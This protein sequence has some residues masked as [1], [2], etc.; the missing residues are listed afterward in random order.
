M[1]I[2]PKMRHTYVGI[3]SHRDTHTAVFIDCFFEKLGEITFKNRPSEFPAFL[4]DALKLRQDDTDL[5]FGLEDVSMYGRTLSVFFQKNNLRIKHVNSLLVSRERKNQNVTEKTDSV[6]AECA[7]RVLLSKLSELPD[8]QLDDKYWILRT[9]VTHRDFI[10]KQNASSKNHLHNLVVQH[11]PNYCELFPNIDAKSALAF[12]KRYPSP[13]TLDGTTHEEL[14]KFLS[15]ASDYRVGAGKPGEVK[16]REILEGL[17]DTA[18]EFQEIRDEAVRTSIRHIEYNTGEVKKLDKAIALFLAEFDC[19]L[20]SMAGI[21]IIAAAQLLACIG[22]IKKFPT[23]A[24]LARYSGVAPVSYS[25]GR[26]DTQYANKRGNRE[27][28]SILY[29]LAVRLITTLG[30]TG[31]MMNPFFYEYYHKK[32]SEGKTKRQALKCVQRRL[33]NIIWTMLTNHEEYV[34]PPMFE[35]PEKET[36]KKAVKS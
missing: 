24:K 31:K 3:D 35:A 34:N 30:P 7:A 23:P 20:T 13:T 32:L 15:E 10:V 28:N 27:L 25:S 4:S 18:V 8:A 9:L 6:D 19:T 17:Q 33:V 12:F 11:Y 22:D 14:A 26:K 16:A 29:L 1:T 36:A 21:D 2:H 5:L